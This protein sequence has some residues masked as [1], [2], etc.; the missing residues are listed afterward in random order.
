MK[1]YLAT[2]LESISKISVICLIL[3][4]KVFGYLIPLSGIRLWLLLLNSDSLILQHDTIACLACAQ[5][6]ECGVDVGHGKVF[7]LRGDV[8][9]PAKV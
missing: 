8:V 7:S 3:G 4:L 1:S 5:V 6:I 9:P 2:L